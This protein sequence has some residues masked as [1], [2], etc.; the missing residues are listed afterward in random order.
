M[1]SLKRSE[2]LTSDNSRVRRRGEGHPCSRTRETWVVPIDSVAPNSR[3][4][5]FSSICL[6]MA[7]LIRLPREEPAGL[8]LVPFGQGG[9]RFSGFGVGCGF[10]IWDPF[11]VRAP[12]RAPETCTWS[13]RSEGGANLLGRDLHG[14]QIAWKP[15][16]CA[17]HAELLFSDGLKRQAGECN[18]LLLFTSRQSPALSLAKSSISAFSVCAE[19][20]RLDPESRV[21]HCKTW[22]KSPSYRW[23]HGARFF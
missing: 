23:L 5:A 19:E 14:K 22:R 13:T 7:S 20:S 12:D 3:S 6:S 9:R 8:P 10:A 1:S 15:R 16:T 21:A 17:G 18:C 2:G 4:S 11:P